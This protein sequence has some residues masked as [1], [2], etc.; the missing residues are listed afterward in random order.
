MNLTELYSKI[1]E[2]AMNTQTVESYKTGDVY[3]LLNSLN[4]Q[5]PIFVSALN[6]IRYQD[7]LIEAHLTFYMVY[8]L[9]NDSS[10]LYEAQ[11]NAFK[12]IRNVIRHLI[13]EYELDGIE[14][15]EIYP[16]TQKFAD[17][18]CGAYADVV[19]YL[20][21]DDLDCDGFDKE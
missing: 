15:I 3:V 4:I 17:V 9:A 18:N 10:N 1:E 12:V 16:F 20:P 7:N 5:Y 21:M 19:V 6:Y 14:T 2:Y 13:D 8:R 11:D